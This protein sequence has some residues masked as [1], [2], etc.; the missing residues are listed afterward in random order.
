MMKKWP[1]S[2]LVSDH[3]GAR[4]RSVARTRPLRGALT[5]PWHLEAQPLPLPPGHRSYLR[6]MG[7]GCGGGKESRRDP[8]VVISMVAAEQ[9]AK[10]KMLALGCQACLY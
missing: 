6:G 3:G 4:R 9:F 5:A 2:V 8:E 7:M 10:K 1:Y